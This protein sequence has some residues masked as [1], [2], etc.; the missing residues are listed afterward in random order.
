MRNM[1]ITFQYRFGIIYLQKPN[2]GKSELVA[3]SDWSAS[4][5]NILNIDAIDIDN[6]L[7]ES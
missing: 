6:I 7:R 1:Y 5:I 4:T 3:S 2:I